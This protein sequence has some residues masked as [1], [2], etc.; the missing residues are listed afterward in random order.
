MHCR[1]SRPEETDW[2]QIVRL[3]DLLE[4]LQPSP[5]VSLNRAVAVAMAEGPRSGL[6]IVDALDASGALDGYY[7]LHATRADL[8]RRVGS[9]EEAAES[10]SRALE[11][12]TNESERRYLARRLREARK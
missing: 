5:I 10:Y 6:A 12:A 8:L 4:R 2:P 11:L 1:A 9:T 7:L 3:Y